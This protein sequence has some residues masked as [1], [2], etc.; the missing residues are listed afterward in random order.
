MASTWIVRDLKTYAELGR[1]LWADTSQSGVMTVET[2]SAISLLDLTEE[3]A[4]DRASAAL[5]DLAIRQ[6]MAQAT[7]Q[8]LETG[9]F[10]PFFKLSPEERFVLAALHLGRWKYERVARIIRFGSDEQREAVERLAWKAR[11]RIAVA[12]GVTPIGAKLASANC[13]EYDLDRPWTQRFL[14]EE[15]GKGRELLFLQNHLMACDS[16]RR[17]LAVCRDIYFKVEEMLPR[18]SDDDRILRVLENVAQHGKKIR[19]VGEVTFVD[20]LVAF[21]KQRNVQILLALVALL[22]LWR[23]RS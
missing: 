17:S 21:F 13:P 23:L 18:V 9:K 8:A 5:L 1:A 4:L 2:L 10:N 14:D 20:S 11:T 16:C 12:M 3:R 15:V 19:Q 6:G 7:R 22:V